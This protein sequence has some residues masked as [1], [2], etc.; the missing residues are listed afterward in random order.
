VS[1]ASS[2]EQ[3]FRE[4]VGGRVIERQLIPENGHWQERFTMVNSYGKLTDVSGQVM[5]LIAAGVIEVDWTVIRHWD[6]GGKFLK[7]T[8]KGRTVVGNIQHE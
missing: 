4:F 5:V 3:V 7:L 8:D 1:N 6:D 2:V